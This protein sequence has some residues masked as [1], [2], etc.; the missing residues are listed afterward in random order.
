MFSV[1]STDQ[2]PFF[3]LE[4]MQYLTL[5]QVGDLFVFIFLFLSAVDED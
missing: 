2:I 1:K 4:R 5:D 3:G